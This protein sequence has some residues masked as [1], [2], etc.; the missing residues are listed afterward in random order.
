MDSCSTD[1]VGLPKNVYVLWAYLYR[2]TRWCGKRIVLEADHCIPRA[3][4]SNSVTDTSHSRI[5][6]F[7]QIKLSKHIFYK[8]SRYSL[9][10]LPLPRSIP[11]AWHNGA[12]L[13]NEHEMGIRWW[14]PVCIRVYTAV[15]VRVQM[16]KSQN[17]QVVS[18]KARHTRQDA[19]NVAD[20]LSTASPTSVQRS[21]SAMQGTRYSIHV[22][23]YA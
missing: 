11:W 14:C 15:G 16:V 2:T 18:V 6:R 1:H 7:Y 21:F 23:I 9:L 3:L 8:T 17:Y 5:C 4:F 10:G 20:K 19:T 13:Y 12:N 22:I